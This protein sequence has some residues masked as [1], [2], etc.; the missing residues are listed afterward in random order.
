MVRWYWGA[1]G[2]GK[3]R[4]AHT[5][6]V[7]ASGDVTLVYRADGPS[8]RGGRWWFNAYDGELYMIVDDFRPAW[9]SIEHLLKL[10]DRYGCRVECKG[11]FRQMRAKFIWITCP[12]PPGD[13]YVESLEDVEQLCRRITEIKEFV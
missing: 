4:A 12:K 9:C 11:G 8:A 13:C 6:A 7:Q 5:E 3:S 10:L 1:T 2:T